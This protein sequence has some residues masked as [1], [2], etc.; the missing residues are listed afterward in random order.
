MRADSH[1]RA[2]ILS[3]R[4]SRTVRGRSFLELVRPRFFS[5]TALVASRLNMM[6]MA[7]LEAILRLTTSFFS[8]S[9]SLSFLTFSF[10]L[11][12]LP[13]LRLSGCDCTA[14]ATATVLFLFRFFFLRSSR[15]WEA[16]SGERADAAAINLGRGDW[17]CVFAVGGRERERGS[18]RAL[19]G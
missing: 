19:A 13:E 1:R 17:Q 6:D 12:L 10:S 9:S 11:S 16:E 5:M 2:V 15:G 3:W 8:L 18:S 14:A 7:F 4:A